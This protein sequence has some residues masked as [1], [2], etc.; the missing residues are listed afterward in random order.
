MSQDTVFQPI[1]LMNMNKVWE[2]V[3][4]MG[5]PLSFP[6]KKIIS[7]SQSDSTNAGIYYIRHGCVRLSHIASNGQEKV[8]LYMGRGMLFNE[9]PMLN[10]GSDYLFTCMEPTETVFFPKKWITEEFIKEHPDLFLNLLESLSKKSRN[11]YSQL[12]GV[13]IFDAFVNVSR[14]LYSMYLHNKAQDYV[15]PRL[16]QQEIAAFLGIHRSSL[17][18][19]LFRLKD[20]GIIGQYSRKRLEVYDPDRFLEYAQGGDDCN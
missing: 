19:A 11:F 14:I 9:I 15:V 6:A 12:C 13:R 18:K 16:T 4:H 20:E 10:V 7:F 5:T 17:H 3:L 1:I 2:N 8:M